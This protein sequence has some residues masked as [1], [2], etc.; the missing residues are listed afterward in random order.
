MSSP[1]RSGRWASSPLLTP[2]L[3]V[4]LIFLLVELSAKT[5][6]ADKAMKSVSYILKKITIL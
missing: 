6:P 1:S 5:R 3:L 4:L 2:A